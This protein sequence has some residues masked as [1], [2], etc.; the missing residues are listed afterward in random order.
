MTSTILA[1]WGIAAL[2]C[3]LLFVVTLLPDRI[4][5]VVGLIGLVVLLG[6]EARDYRRRRR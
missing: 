5:G 4:G 6:L 2:G 1:Q 3:A